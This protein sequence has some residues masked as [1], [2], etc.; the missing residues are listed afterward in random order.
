MERVIEFKTRKSKFLGLIEI[1]CITECP[2]ERAMVGSAL[3]EDCPQ[4]RGLSTDG[5]SVICEVENGV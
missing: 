2:D 4:F 3:C 1:A 5:K